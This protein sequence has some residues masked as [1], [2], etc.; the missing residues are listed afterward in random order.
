MRFFWTFRSLPE[1][2]HLTDEQKQQVIHRA[3]T[4]KARRA[5]AYKVMVAAVFFGGISATVFI[6]W[7]GVA[8][9][10]LSAMLFG[11][12]VAALTFQVEMWDIRL[13]LRLFLFEHF[14]G[15]KLPVCLRCG[16]DLTGNETD[17]CPECGANI[18]M[19]KR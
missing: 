4:G 7:A 10:S 18:L 13:A 14:R 5:L 8:M 11:T 15:E 2:N 1:L 12:C 6:D 3:V 16:Y 19:P 9:G 17:R